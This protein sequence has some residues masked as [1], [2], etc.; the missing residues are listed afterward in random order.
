MS[1]LNGF[2]TLSYDKWRGNVPNSM[3]AVFRLP[4]LHSRNLAGCLAEMK[5]RIRT[6]LL[7]CTPHS[8]DSII[9]TDLGGSVCIIMGNED[10]GVNPEIASLATDRVAI[11][12]RPGIDSLNVA[13]ASTIFLY[14]AARKRM[15]HR[16]K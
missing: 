5:N 9:E 3:G 15:G 11:P 13:S 2:T 10:V 14:E 1:L 7:A 12:M 4:V 6:R 8:P 16:R